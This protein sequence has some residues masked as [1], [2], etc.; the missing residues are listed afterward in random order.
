MTIMADA[1]AP[2]TGGVDTH[3]DFHI[4]AAL[5][6]R[7]GQLGVERFDTTPAGYQALTVWLQ[8][9]GPI[10]RVGVEGT[11]TWGAALT[12]VLLDRGV[13]VVDVDRPNRQRRRRTGKT[14]ELDAIAAARA[15]QGGDVAGYAKD[16]AGTV[17]AIRVLRVA[18]RSATMGRRV[19]IN[20]LRSLV[21]T[22]PA[23]LREDLRRLSG[24]ALIT[25]AAR[26]RPGPN[27][28][29]VAATKIAMRVLARRIIDLE[30]ELARLDLV[31]EPLVAQ[32]APGLVGVDPVSRTFTMR[33]R[34]SERMSDAQPG[35]PRSALLLTGVQGRDC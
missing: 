13:C 21:A 31:L 19:A 26:F 9:F 8:S 24:P 3:R 18:R 6:H 14:D 23:E 4:A 29:A 34:P 33:G 20:Q 35:A 25:T 22:G 27:T 1:R 16:R 28:T 12:R 2:I 5:D 7:G 11:G 10:E 32:A 30:D 15:A 17:E